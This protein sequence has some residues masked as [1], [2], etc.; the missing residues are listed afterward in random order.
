MSETKKE[1]LPRPLRFSV[2]EFLM[3]TEGGRTN[4]L[5]C[6]AVLP[7][8]SKRRIVLKLRNPG[9]FKANQGATSLAAELITA[10][11]A[12]VLGIPV[13]DFGIAEVDQDF[14]DAVAHA[15][16]Q[17]LLR[18]NLGRN[19]ATTLLRGGIQPWLWSYQSGSGT[20]R[21]A[22]DDVISLD[23]TI[24][25]HDR[26]KGNAN[27]LWDGGEKVYVIDHSL[28]VLVYRW[29]AAMLQS[30]AL[31]PNEDVRDHCTFD[32][33]SGK[34][35]A[36]ENVHQAWQARL[37]PQDWAAIRAEV[38]SEW[39][40]RSGDVD[41]MIQFLANRARRFHDISSSLRGVVT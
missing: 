24:I 22:L 21:Q 41:T 23:A 2:R 7:D 3:R 33:L 39:E 32:F 4:P 28:S 18:R 15:P 30:S 31:F 36:F 34:G 35:C 8:G 14:V 11:L 13:P 26:S 17:E 10:T 12:R 20:L 1:R 19:F 9:T 16:T 6:G 40:S 25:N 38:P 37:S 27:L 29:E 5:I